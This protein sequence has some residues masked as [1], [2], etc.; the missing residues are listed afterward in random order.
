MFATITIPL[1][2][3]DLD[4]YFCPNL[5][6]EIEVS[7]EADCVPTWNYSAHEV[8]KDEVRGYYVNDID[9]INGNKPCRYPKIREALEKMK[10]E[11]YLPER[12]N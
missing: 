11:D 6:V 3:L 4:T 7:V 10:L 8:G 5:N 9:S 12:E 1:E 2:D